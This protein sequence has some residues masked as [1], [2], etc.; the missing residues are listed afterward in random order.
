MLI[1]LSWDT[2]LQPEPPPEEAVTGI[3][4]LA[5]HERTPAHDGLDATCTAHLDRLGRNAARTKGAMEPDMF[6]AAFDCRARDFH[7]D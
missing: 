7:R 5:V 2:V 1:E 6:D 4:G 3:Y